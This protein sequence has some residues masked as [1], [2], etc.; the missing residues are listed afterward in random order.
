MAVNS[1]ALQRVDGATFYHFHKSGNYDDLWRVG[2]EITF[3]GKSFNQYYAYYSDYKPTFVLYNQIN[4]L[5]TLPDFVKDLQESAK[6]LDF[7]IRE[8]INL[9]AKLSEIITDLTVWIR[10]EIFE[11]VRKTQFPDRPNRKTCLFVCDKS[12]INYWKGQLAAPSVDIKIFR[13]S[14]TGT[15]F[16]ANER[17]VHRDKYGTAYFCNNAVKYW[18]GIQG[19]DNE[20][21]EILFLGKAKIIDQIR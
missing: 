5:Q 7:N 12:K 21:E 2:N 10:E 8:L 6:S 20:D 1:S 16:R 19:D 9:P 18:Q 14:L 17:Y 15:I 3:D 11:D 13:L 4:P